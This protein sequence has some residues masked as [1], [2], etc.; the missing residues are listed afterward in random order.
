[1]RLST[2]AF[3]LSCCLNN[4]L[5]TRQRLTISQ[6][7]DQSM[8]HADSHAC[9]RIASMC[10]L[11][12]PTEI[13]VET[14]DVVSLAPS[15]LGAICCHVCSHLAQAVL[16]GK[17]R[18]WQLSFAWSVQIWHAHVHVE[19]LYRSKSSALE[20]SDIAYFVRKEANTM[21]TDVPLSPAK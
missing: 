4:L 12:S 9:N 10:R 17:E 11:R 6:Q 19:G 7:R 21:D 3:P 20:L 8:K 16:H 15:F 14:R 1:M 5:S 13:C 2:A 18:D